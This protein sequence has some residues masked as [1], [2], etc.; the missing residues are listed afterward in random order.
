MNYLVATPLAY[1]SDV[2]NRPE[3]FFQDPPKYHRPECSCQLLFRNFGSYVSTH[4]YV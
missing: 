1:L 3:L 2:E 4:I